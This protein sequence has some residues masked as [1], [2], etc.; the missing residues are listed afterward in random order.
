MKTITDSIKQFQATGNLSDSVAKVLLVSENLMD[1]NFID[2]ITE[3][4][5]Y[6]QRNNLDINI[7]EIKIRL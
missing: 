1:E 5:K 3:A 7:V 4:V 2:R 6:V